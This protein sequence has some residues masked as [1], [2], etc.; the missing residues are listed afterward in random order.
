MCSELDKGKA[1]MLVLL[2]LSSAFDT[3]DH[4][5]L[6]E[7]MQKEVVLQVVP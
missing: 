1:I 5:I 4:E 2:D 3:I 6:V 7:R